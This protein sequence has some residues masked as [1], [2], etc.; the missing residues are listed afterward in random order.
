MYSVQWEDAHRKVK[1]CLRLP[2]TGRE[3]WDRSFLSAFK[4]TW[5]VPW[6]PMSV[7]QNY[8]MDSYKLMQFVLPCYSRPQKQTG[9][10]AVCIMYSQLIHNIACV[11]ISFHNAG[12]TPLLVYITF[13][14][15]CSFT[16][17]HLVASIFWLLWIMLLI[18]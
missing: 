14:Y 6:F 17:G 12:N 8:E 3:A 16:D 15:I 2:E 1:E 9:S 5:P 13:C 18:W 4:R 10:V 7:L 11:K